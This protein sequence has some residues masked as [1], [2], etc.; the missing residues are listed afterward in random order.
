[1]QGALVLEQ[2]PFLL[3][4]DQ[5]PSCQVL[6][7]LL[8]VLV[9]VLVWVPRNQSLPEANSEPLAHLLPP[10]FLCFSYICTFVYTSF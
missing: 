9:L 2:L 1:V 8:L 7:R 4:L 5:L 10:L 3:V 6:E